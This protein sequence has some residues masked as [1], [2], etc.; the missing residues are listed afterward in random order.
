MTHPRLVV[1]LGLG[2]AA[3][4][5]AMPGGAGD[6]T[7]LTGLGR[8]VEP[9]SVRPAWR[10]ELTEGPVYRLRPHEL[11]SPAYSALLDRVVVGSSGGEVVC[12]DAGNG[13]V[14]W[15]R[16][17][18]G[19]VSST[20]VFDGR[21][22]FLGTDDGGMVCLD[23]DSGEERWHYS[24]QGAVQQRPLL[25]EDAVVFVDGTN[26]IYAI[27]RADGAWRWQY[28]RSAPVDFA[29][30]GEAK[31]T[32]DGRR[33]FAG[34]SDGHLV[35]LDARDGAVSWTRDLAPEHD[36]FQDVDA[37]PVLIGGTLFAASAA[38][39]VYALSP[40]DGTVRFTVPVAG[41]N[42]LV[43]HEGA[44]IA[45]ID[46]GEVWRITVDGRVEWRTRLPGGA[47]SVAVSLGDV[48]AVSLSQGALH[49]LRARDGRPMQRF[50]PGLGLAAPPSVGEDGGIYV[51]SNAGVLYALRPGA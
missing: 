35:A 46:R 11:A 41:V 31:P 16:S 14:L 27:G 25:V 13:A 30:A 47:P 9:V 50:L 42:R 15:R 26:S 20:P 49:F 17:M 7:P 39:G 51:L 32:T 45:S 4:G 36:R 21:R 34:F 29:L 3:C 23:A 43:E 1:A 6:D 5:A 18:G 40:E 19:A 2:L 28:R 37:A 44:L 22:V 10:I 8:N 12:V 38:T 24:V 48:L 33:I